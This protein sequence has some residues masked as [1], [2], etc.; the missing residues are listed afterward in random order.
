MKEQTSLGFSTVS[1]LFVL[2]NNLPVTMTEREIFDSQKY[3]TFHG[4]SYVA[5]PKFFADMVKDFQKVVFIIGIPDSDVSN[6]FAQGL[7]NILMQPEGGIEFFNQLPVAAKTRVADD[8][9]QIRY[10]KAG[11]MIHD[12]IYLLSNAATGEYRTIIG[13]A[14]MSLSAFGQ[15]NR[16]FENIRID[17]GQEL[18]QNRRKTPSFSY[19]DI[20]RRNLLAV[21]NNFS[22]KFHERY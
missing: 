19:G 17:D 14:N 4:V 6:S 8:A 5:S 9:M 21:S 15:E 18:Y 10:G 12:K 22:T 13:S 11:V 7:E 1:S 16:N 2:Y 20:R 3:D